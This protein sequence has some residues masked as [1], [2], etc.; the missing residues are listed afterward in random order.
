M[1]NWLH[2]LLHDPSRGWDPV[3]SAHSRD[4]SQRAWEDLQPGLVDDLERRTGGL[5]GKRVLDL[6]AGPAQYSIEFARRGAL[7][8]W[9][10]ISRNYQRRARQLASDAGVEVEFSLGYL[11]QARKFLASPFDLVFCRLCWNYCRGDRA[12]A[13]LI[14]RLIKPG[15]AAYVEANTE[16]FGAPAGLRR[17]IYF[18]NNRLSWKLGHPYPP[19][20]RIARMFLRFPLDTAFVDQSSALVDRLFLI[21]TAGNPPAGDGACGTKAPCA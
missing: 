5:K 17:C 13:R 15:G 19:R 16:V 2:S 1:I 3:P 10:D 20:G 6:G 18:L 21:K 11:E 8:V 12:F 14:Y 9:H 4:Y 7:V